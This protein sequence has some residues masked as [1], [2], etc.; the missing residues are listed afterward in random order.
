MVQ[1]LLLLFFWGPPSFWE[2]KDPKNWTSDEAMELL[3]SSPWAR[4]DGARIYLASAQH[5]RIAEDILLNRPPDQAEVIA[6]ED[7]Y[8]IAMKENPGKYM[9]LAV[10]LP[11]PQS[12]GNAEES[13]RMEEDCIL[14]VGKKRYKMIGHFP[15]T[16]SD[17]VLRLLYPRVVDPSIKNFSFELY[18]PSVTKPYRM[19]EFFTKEMVWRG[20]LEY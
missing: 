20:K 14:K 2:S 18:L 7:D 6:P 12:L 9:V 8:R 15:P 3:T 17:P 4:T 1:A 10:L 13:R 11:D 16:P 5:L 19:Y